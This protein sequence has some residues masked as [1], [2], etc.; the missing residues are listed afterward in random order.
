MLPEERG[1]VEDVEGDAIGSARALMSSIVSRSSFAL[2]DRMSVGRVGVTLQFHQIQ[3]ALLGHDLV[4]MQ[5]EVREC[6]EDFG[7]YAALNRG[8]DFGLCACCETA[9]VSGGLVWA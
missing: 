9:V 4:D 1:A 3:L 6:L 2:L 8:L 7:T 5:L